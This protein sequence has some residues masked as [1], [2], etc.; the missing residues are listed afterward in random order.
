MFYVTPKEN[1]TYEDM[2]VFVPAG[3]IVKLQRSFMS[4]L[5]CGWFHVPGTNHTIPLGFTEIDRTLF[6]NEQVMKGL[7]FVLNYMVNADDRGEVFDPEPDDWTE[8]DRDNFY[9]LLKWADQGPASV[10]VDD[11]EGIQW[12]KNP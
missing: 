6:P 12:Q 5:D 3:T 7:E 4:D 11:E 9:A 8:E 1:H 10:K 2:D